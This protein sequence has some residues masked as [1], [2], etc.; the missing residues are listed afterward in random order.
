MTEKGRLLRTLF[1]TEGQEHINIKFCRGT[2]D[3]ISPEALCRE[4][5]WAIFQME[6]GLVDV[7]SRFGDSDL[8]VIDVNTV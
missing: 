6:N 5:N 7:R 4:A 8:P 3:D 1:E 2:S